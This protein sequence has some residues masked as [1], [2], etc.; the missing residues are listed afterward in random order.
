ML[1]LPWDIRDMQDLGRRAQC[2]KQIHAVQ[3]FANL[4]VG[5]K[6]DSESPDRWLQR[7]RLVRQS[8]APKITYTT[9]VI[10]GQWI[11]NAIFAAS[12]AG[13]LQLPR[14][15]VGPKIYKFEK[16]FQHGRQLLV[17]TA[18]YTLWLSPKS[19]IVPLGSTA[20]AQQMP[21]EG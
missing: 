1:N 11:S 5:A 20:F 21:M 10:C 12:S 8:V 2:E 13:Q 17:S 6:A 18:C 9:I 16:V 15:E 3:S 14:Q 7:L 19:I 4:F